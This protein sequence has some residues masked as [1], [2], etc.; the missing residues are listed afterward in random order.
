MCDSTYQ[1]TWA[2]HFSKVHNNQST[3]K[4][5]IIHANL[6]ELQSPGQA[7]QTFRLYKHGVGGFQDSLATATDSNLRRL[8]DGGNYEAEEDFPSAEED[9]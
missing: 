1:G 8:A 2:E 3:S 6:L 5:P 9:V 7:P 4:P